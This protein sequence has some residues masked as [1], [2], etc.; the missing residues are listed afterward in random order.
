MSEP[1]QARLLEL[2]ELREGY[3][4]SRV[5]R[6]ATPAGS[7]VL[8]CAHPRGYRQV[9]VDGRACYVHRI[10]YIL[11]H[12][13]LAADVDHVDGDRA[14][15][16]AG[17]LRAATRSQNLQNTATFSSNT[18]GCRGVCWH[19]ASG[20]WYVR[21]GAAGVTYS[22]F[23]SNYDEACVAASKLREQHHGAYMRGGVSL[24]KKLKNS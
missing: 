6:G 23:H 5:R 16:W 19:R 4:Y 12:G 2:F 1:T 21:I 3:L 11:L 22:S 15:N 24:A 8:G 13:D 14:N 17:N 10:V 7:A 9:R 18:S 20:K